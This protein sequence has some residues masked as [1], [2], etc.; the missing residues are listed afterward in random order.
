MNPETLG[1]TD[2][3]TRKSPDIARV[4]TQISE[5]ALHIDDKNGIRTQVP[6]V[7]KPSCSRNHLEKDQ[8][9]TI[10]TQIYGHTSEKVGGI[11]G[12]RAPEC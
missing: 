9:G 6:G 1:K 7:E 12:P 10:H 5:S 2:E 4:T 11:A 3:K 8:L